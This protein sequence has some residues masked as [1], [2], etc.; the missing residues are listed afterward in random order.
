MG[1]WTAGPLLPLLHPHLPL[2]PEALASSE[3]HPLLSFSLPLSHHHPPPVQT[4]G[5]VSDVQR[6]VNTKQWPAALCLDLGA[7]DPAE[8]R[9]RRRGNMRERM[10]SSK[11]QNNYTQWVMR[12]PSLQGR[13]GRAGRRGTLRRERHRGNS[14]GHWACLV[15][16]TIT[17]LP[18]HG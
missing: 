6:V 5:A 18:L 4:H 14:Q 15:E 10:E 7:R 9:G 17:D 8:L 1:F 12:A 16:T 13:C 11:M 3:Q 2:G